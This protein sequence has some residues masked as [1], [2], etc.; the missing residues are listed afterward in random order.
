VY[1]SSESGAYQVHAW[2][3]ASDT[4]RQVTDHP[5]GVIEGDVTLDGDRVLFWQDETG[6]EAGRWYAQPFA[7]GEPVPY[8]DGVPEGWS[9]GLTQA[10]GIVGAVI[11]DPDGFALYIAVDGGPS[12]EM[13]RSTEWLAIGGLEQGRSHLAGLSADGAMLALEH[14]EHGDAIHPGLRI[15]DPRSGETI[16]DLVDDG[17]ALYAAAWSLLPGD[18][19]LAVSHERGTDFSPA[20]W[21]LV[22]GEWLDL[23]VDLEGPVSVADW[24]PDGRALLLTHNDRGRDR[25]YRYDLTT[26][27][28]ERLP[29][30]EGSIEGA[31]VR[32]AQVRPDGDVWFELTS[33]TA[34]P[35]VLDLSG[36]NLLPTP[37]APAGWPF[38]PW[39]FDNGRGDIVHGFYL[40]PEGDGPFPV[41]MRAHGGPTW[42]DKDRWHPEIAA[43]VDMG[44][45]VGLV[46]YRGST[47]YGRVWRDRLI[48]DIGG[49]ELVDVNAGL[50]D[51]VAR[52][53]ADPRRAVIGG[54][55]WGGYITLLELGKHPE[56]W[57]A[58]IAGVPVG[59]YEVGY[60]D[61]SPELQVYDRALIGGTPDQVPELMAD[62]NPIN[63]V[64]GVVAP[65][66]F[67]IGEN[68]TR[69]PL[70]QAMA[71]VDRLA[72]RGHSHE[73][74]M[75]DAG[76]GSYD[77]DEEVRQVGAI[78]DFLADHVPG[79]ELPD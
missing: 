21:D 67:L 12:K 8:L 18:Q 63:F 70:R 9:Q 50:A 64:D 71:Y 26:R 49:P 66:I 15:V 10:P 2:D 34:P 61:L 16:A 78:L 72:E 30:P 53:I 76:H 55:S 43:Y 68:D 4:H 56:L 5:I 27:Q 41:I 48:G 73:L 52:G 69:C 51:L 65:V 59:D 46:N 17:L 6:S 42:E 75:F 58:G 54:W 35:A 44:F 36:A 57:V 45:A 7:G 39:R 74:V 11:S 29:T 19:R 60:E 37:A 3:R 20:I 23:A 38:V 28:V 1:V 77:V 14:A 62:R 25:L 32:P 33:G 40:V 47:G 31:R 22:S 13:L 24:W 79:V